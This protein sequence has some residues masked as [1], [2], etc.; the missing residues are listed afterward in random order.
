[1]PTTKKRVNLALS[2]DIYERL[3][4]YKEKN[5]ISSDAGAC[6]MLIIRQLDTIAET[7]Q[8][9]NIVSRFTMEELQQLS[10]IGL[11]MIKDSSE[12]GT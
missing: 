7:E 3:Q 1:M 11:S 9:M 6:L 12:K 2:D 10:N 8:M 5:G 4:R